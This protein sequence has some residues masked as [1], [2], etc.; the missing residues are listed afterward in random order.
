MPSLVGRQSEIA[1]PSHRARRES[2]VQLVALVREPSP[3]SASRGSSTSSSSES[4]L[5]LSS[6]GS[7]RGACSPYGEGVTFWRWARSSRRRP[8]SSRVTRRPRW[9]RSSPPSAANVRS[10]RIRD[11]GGPRR[12]RSRRAGA[13]VLQH[14]RPRAA[15]RCRHHIDAA[16]SSSTSSTTWSSGQ[17]ASN[18]VVCSGAPELGAPPVVERREAERLT[19]SLSPLSDEETRP[20]RRRARPGRSTPRR[21]RSSLCARGN[22]PPRRAVL[23]H[24][25]GRAAEGARDGAGDHRRVPRPPRA[26]AE[27]VAPGCGGPRAYVLE[28]VA[29]ERHGS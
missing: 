13:E 15:G 26:R 28:R 6:S 11:A 29:R 5:T 18:L 17:A 7:A 19:I 27:G 2:S 14:R 8:G 20:A 22:P 3:G 1:P 16:T 9:S 25:G 23:A 12:A 24:P 10:C 4:S 21:A